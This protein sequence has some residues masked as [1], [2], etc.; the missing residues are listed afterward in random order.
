MPTVRN[1]YAEFTRALTYLNRPIEDEDEDD[2]D[3]DEDEI[4]WDDDA[5]ETFFD[6]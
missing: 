2:L 5:E 4:I 3:I 1:A 6:S